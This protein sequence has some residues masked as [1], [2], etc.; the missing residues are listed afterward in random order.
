MLSLIAGVLALALFGV[1]LPVWGMIQ[2][3]GF[4]QVQDAPAH[5][6]IVL[7]LTL[8]VVGF[9]VFIGMLF[10]GVF[11][12]EKLSHQCMRSGNKQ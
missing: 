2:V 4:R 1:M 12:Y 7:L 8:P 5:G 10:F 11:I 3:Y 9:F 6:G